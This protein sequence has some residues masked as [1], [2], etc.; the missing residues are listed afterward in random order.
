MKYEGDIIRPP[1]EA[2]SLLLQITVGCSHNQC[3]FCRAYKKKRFRIKEF[4]EIE[5]D[6]R[7]A[8]EYPYPDKVFLCDGD[9]LI[10]P[11]KKLVRILE[12]IRKYLKGVE[13]VGVYAN[14]KSILKKTPDELAQLRELGLGI[15]YFGLETGSDELLIQIH[16]GADSRKMVAAGR[17]IKEAGIALSVTVL[18][19][20]GG[21]E[22]SID[23]A[24]ET[25]K[26]LSEID[27]DYVGALTVMV[28][29]GTPLYEQYAAGTYRRPEPYDLIRELGCMI[30]GSNFT[31]CLFTS[32]HA[33]NYLAVRA[34]LPQDK[35]RVLAAIDGVLRSGGR[36][37]LRP[38]YLRRL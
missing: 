19:G 38:D 28:I 10:V 33:S 8:A 36:G 12:S 16:K 34:R 3:T 15:V 6:I 17:R 20:I 1:S 25:A 21:T 29:P 18:L 24:R 9:A 35:E 26:V 27:P 5:E 4:E 2:G 23:H 11:Q 13:R 22:K 32:N 37:M 7:E 30:A 14:A 31:K